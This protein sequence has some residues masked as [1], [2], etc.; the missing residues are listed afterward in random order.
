M[1]R[2]RSLIL[3]P[4]VAAL[5]MATGC[6]TAE[7]DTAQAPQSSTGT[8]ELP[9]GVYGP[10]APGY[11]SPVVAKAEEPAPAAPIADDG[12]PAASAPVASG[13]SGPASNYHPDSSDHIEK[14][15]AGLKPLE[16]INTGTEKPAAPN[17]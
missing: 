17:S 12:E 15:E 2:N 1:L 14:M 7:K 9:A 10:P 6:K 8:T 13:Q 16:A 4:L 11:S 3:L 5:S